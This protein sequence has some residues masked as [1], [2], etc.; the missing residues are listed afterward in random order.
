MFKPSDL[1]VFSHLKCAGGGINPKSSPEC[2]DAHSGGGGGGGGVG[3][4]VNTTKAKIVEVF[5]RIRKLLGSLFHSN[6][7]GDS[8]AFKSALGLPMKIVVM[9]FI[10]VVVHRVQRS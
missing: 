5:E 6:E 10:I 1:F 7:A 3:W 4:A 8:E 9:L 2:H